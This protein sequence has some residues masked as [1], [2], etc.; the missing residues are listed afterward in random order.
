MREFAG[1]APALRRLDRGARLVYAAF[2][3]F[4]LAGL[5]SATLLHL[6]GMGT[7]ASGA[8]AW[9][10]GDEAEMAYP[11]SYRQILEITH[12][13]LF[14]EPIVWLVVAHLY[15]LSGGR[16]LVSLGTLAA[17][18]AQIALP[19][20]IAYG[21]AALSVLALP[22][23]VAVVAGLCWMIVDSLRELWASSS[24]SS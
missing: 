17:I 23:S 8:A 16:A 2:L 10:R 1:R 3:A 20:G 5:V 18:G 9:W 11:K 13:H 7:S 6:D 22:V 24:P 21:P 14:T 4:L 15:H 12:F 19:W